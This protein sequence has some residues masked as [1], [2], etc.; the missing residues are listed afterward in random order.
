MAGYFAGGQKIK[1]T[2]GKWR[3]SIISI[4]HYHNHIFFQNSIFR[5][6][7]L[8]CL[9]CLTET[10]HP[11]RCPGFSSRA[12]GTDTAPGFPVWLTDSFPDAPFSGYILHLT[13]KRCF[14]LSLTF[15]RISS[16]KMYSLLLYYPGNEM[17]TDF[18]TE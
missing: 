1:G 12:A 8:Y 4:T 11:F 18:Y 3:F 7:L 16:P 14:H 9:R 2:V 5:R 6:P 17:S 13:H 10:F 15:P